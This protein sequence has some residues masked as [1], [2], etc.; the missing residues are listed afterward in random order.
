MS[1]FRCQG[2]LGDVHQSWRARTD[3]SRRIHSSNR[4]STVPPLETGA[5]VV[6]PLGK[7]CTYVSLYAIADTDSLAFCPIY[8]PIDVSTYELPE[9]LALSAEPSLSRRS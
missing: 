9:V 7:L 8:Q 6:D 5:R 1:D 3:P 4:R 2:W